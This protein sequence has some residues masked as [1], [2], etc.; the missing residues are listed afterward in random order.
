V[1]LYDFSDGS[2]ADGIDSSGVSANQGAESVISFLLAL[3][4]LSELRSQRLI[5]S[6]DDAVRS[7]SSRGNI[8]SM[9]AG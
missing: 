6:Q 9:S 4:G 5:A 7:V 2:V 8:K 1:A 3:I